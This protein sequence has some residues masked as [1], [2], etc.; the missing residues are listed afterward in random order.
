MKN[1][2]WFLAGSACFIISQPLLRMPILQQLQNSTEFLLAYQLNPLTIG[3]LIALSA[4]IFEESFRFLFKQFLIKPVKCAFRQP[5]IFGLGHGIA[6]ALIILL[7]A[8]SYVPISQLGLAVF[9]R[10][11]AIIL[12]VG[13]TTIVW[14]GFQKNRRILY[15]FIAIV[16]H[17]FVNSLIPLLSSFPNS[18]LLIEG[19]LAVIDVF[20]IIYSYNSRKLYIKED[21]Q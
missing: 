12:H 4:G 21:L 18:I 14:N 5:I 15:L 11:L 13:L 20:M 17:G 19:A 8:L 16:L 7:P 10:I 6:E 3:I 9:E 2:L 1:L